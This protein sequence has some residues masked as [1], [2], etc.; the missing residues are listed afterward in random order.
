MFD[1]LAPLLA[2]GGVVFGATLLSIGVERSAAARAL[3][4]VYNRKGVFSNTADS[5]DTLR[6]ALDQRF[7]VVEIDVVG[8]AALFVARDLRGLF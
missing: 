1:N 8:C 6:A 2:P 7:N 5:V 4:R 3:M